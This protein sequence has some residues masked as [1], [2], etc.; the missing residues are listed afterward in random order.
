VVLFKRKALLSGVIFE[1]KLDS[2]AFSH[3]LWIVQA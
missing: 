3:Y 1:K 2:C